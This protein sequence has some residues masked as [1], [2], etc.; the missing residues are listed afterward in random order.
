MATFTE[1]RTKY[2]FYY[3]SMLLGYCN[4]IRTKAFTTSNGI[5]VETDHLYS[6]KDGCN[7]ELRIKGNNLIILNIGDNTRSVFVISNNYSLI[8]EQDLSKK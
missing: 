3:D 5:F 7:Y 8:T 6:V 1:E 2:A 4:D